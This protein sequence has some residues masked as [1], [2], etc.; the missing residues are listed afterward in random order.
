MKKKIITKKVT[1]VIKEK[2]VAQVTKIDESPI[3]I[4]VS[5]KPSRCAIC[6]I[7]TNRADANSGT[8]LCHESCE[9]KFLAKSLKV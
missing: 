5:Q 7:I 4:F 2:K 3:K 8:Y 1:K 9:K 6:G